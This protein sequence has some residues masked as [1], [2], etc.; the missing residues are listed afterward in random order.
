MDSKDMEF[1]KR[2]CSGAVS[3]PWQNEM[4]ETGCFDD[5]NEFRKEDGT[6]VD[7]LNPDIPP[8]QQNPP[9]SNRNIFDRLFKRKRQSLGPPSSQSEVT[10][11]ES[12][13]KQ[14]KAMSSLEVENVT[15]D[16]MPSGKTNLL[17]ESTGDNLSDKENAVAHKQEK[18]SSDDRQDDGKKIDHITTENQISKTNSH[19][20]MD[21]SAISHKNIKSKSRRSTLPVHSSF[22]CCTHR[23]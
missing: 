11:Q 16:S 23:K 14:S 1:Y 10:S 8:I 3:I 2:F 9:S 13:M 7:N 5:L 20:S 19:C 18:T 12:T 6:L 17:S 15:V 4:L 21:S 22:L